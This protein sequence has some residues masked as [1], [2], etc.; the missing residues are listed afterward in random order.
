MKAIFLKQLSKQLQ[1]SLLST[2]QSAKM[3]VESE[4][5][6][7]KRFQVSR[8]D[9]SHRLS[10]PLSLMKVKQ[11]IPRHAWV[12]LQ[13]GLPRLFSSIQMQQR[14]Q[15]QNR[16]TNLPWQLKIIMTQQLLMTASH[17]KTQLKEQAVQHHYH[18]KAYAGYH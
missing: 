4:I 9:L 11:R 8:L 10:G 6:L 17:R 14:S 2:E 13:Y 5:N 7:S 18:P 12:S 1:N 15:P 16:P 3:V